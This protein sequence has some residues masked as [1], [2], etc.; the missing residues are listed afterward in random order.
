MC[1]AR[2]STS[3]R[4]GFAMIFTL[5]SILSWI[6]MTDWAERKLEDIS[7]GYLKLNC[8]QGQCYGVL[9][10]YRICFA[11]TIFHAI[12]AG[13]MYNVSSSRDWR[14]SIQN[15]YWFFK[16]LAW[17]GLVVLSFFIPNPFFIGWGLWIDLPAAVLFILIQIVLLIDFS[18]TFKQWEETEDKKYLAF[19]LLI[20]FGAFAGCLT[21][22]GLL[23]AWF[24][25]FSCQL[26]Q[27]FITFNLIL[28]VAVSILAISPPVQEINPKSG[29]AQAAMVVAYATYLAASSISSEPDSDDDASVSLCNPLN[30][31]SKTKTTSI[32]LGSIFTFLALAYSTS[33]AATQSGALTKEDGVPLISDQPRHVQG[34]VDSG[35]L[36]SSSLDEEGGPVDDEQDGVQ[37]NYSFFHI[38]FLLGSCY[39]SQLI[40]NWDKVSIE[41]NND[42]AVVGKGWGAVWVKIV[43]SWVVI[44]LYGWTLIAPLV[45]PDREW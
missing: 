1:G 31:S 25:G 7:F 35:A 11:N 10:V 22:T 13:I 37:Y 30:E 18:Y 21:L 8:P 29:L 33:R 12:F 4:I 16:F 5:T 19:L 39:L 40:T 27:F 44:L 42:T 14:S 41:H 36:P 9:S 43:S 34:A 24:G 17:A 45:L 38:I 6:T 32:V 20:T 28:C 2:T 26:N 23:Y 3:S 15:G